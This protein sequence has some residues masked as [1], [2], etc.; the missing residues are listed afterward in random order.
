MITLKQPCLNSL[1]VVLFL[2][3]LGLTAQSQSARYTLQLAAVANEA[4][5]EAQVKRLQARGIAAYS[6]ATVLPG[7]GFLFRVRVGRFDSQRQAR[8]A[9]EELHRGG[10]APEFFVTH[11]ETAPAAISPEARP[12]APAALPFSMTEGRVELESR[13]WVVNFKA[14]GSINEQ[15]NSANTTFSIVPGFRDRNL[16]EGRLTWRVTRR[17]KLRFDFTQFNTSADSLQLGLRN[18]ETAFAVNAGI[19]SDLKIKQLRLSY[20]WQ[21]FRIGDKFKIGPLVE[22]RAL[23]LDATLREQPN[24]FRGQ[25]GTPTV[26]RERFA[27]LLPGVGADLNFALHRRINFFATVSGLPAGRYGHIFDGEAGIRI[28]PIGHLNLVGGYRVLN[29]AAHDGSDFAKL[30]LSG[31]FVG[32]QIIWGRPGERD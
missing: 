16:P 25:N 12:A 20:S 1:S 24:P 13:Y 31:P 32:A 22:A 9:G 5:A 10:L 26:E 2:L 14:A 28:A 17:S 4:D 3:C 29:F 19:V 21:G 27:I 8:A 11:Y 30:R 18:D 6:Q 15:I 7:K 23:W